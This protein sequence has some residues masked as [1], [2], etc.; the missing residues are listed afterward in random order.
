MLKLIKV[1]QNRIEN[2]LW[3]QSTAVA[4]NV[5]QKPFAVFLPLGIHGLSHSIRI[6]KDEITRVEANLVCAKSRP[7]VQT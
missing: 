2:V 3:A 5:Q 4:E 1:D 7:S 6:K